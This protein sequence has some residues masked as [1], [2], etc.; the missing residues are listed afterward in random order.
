M[1]EKSAIQKWAYALSLSSLNDA[2]GHIASLPNDNN[3]SNNK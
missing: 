2:P 3:R 1:I